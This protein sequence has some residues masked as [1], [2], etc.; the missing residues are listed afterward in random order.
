MNL[1]LADQES[2]TLGRVW[3]PVEDGTEEE[4]PVAGEGP[5]GSR[6]S[7]SLLDSLVLGRIEINRF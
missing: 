2:A 4:G 6:D 7:R 5:K 3:L 1:N